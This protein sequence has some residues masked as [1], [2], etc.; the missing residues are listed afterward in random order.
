MFA[1]ARK[2]DESNPET[3]LFGLRMW[4]LMVIRFDCY[5]AV[6]CRIRCY[7]LEIVLILFSKQSIFVF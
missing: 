1:C 3:Q 6:F 4:L 2:S 7:F 5:D